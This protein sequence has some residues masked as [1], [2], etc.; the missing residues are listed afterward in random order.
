MKWIRPK[1]TVAIPNGKV[2][3]F[4]TETTGLFPRQGHRPYLFTFANLQCETGLIWFDVDPFTRRVKYE[5]NPDGLARLKQFFSDPTN[6]V[7]AHNAQFDKRMA[8]AALGFETKVQWFCT[9]SLIRVV[10]SDAPIKLKDF[11]AKYLGITN[12]D[13]EAV[14]KATAAARRDAKKKGWAMADAVEPDYWMAPVECR[15]YGVIDALR[16]ATV[17]N[18]LF[19]EVHRNKLETVLERE[20]RL[21]P[22]MRRI[23]DRGVHIDRVKTL[24]LIADL[25][26]KRRLFEL[27]ARIYGGSEMNFRSG[28]QLVKKL[29]GDFKEPVI[30]STK[31][32]NPAMDYDAMAAMEH[33]L[34]KNILEMRACTTTIKALDDYM[35]FM[36]KEERGW[37]I[38]PNLNQ[39]IP[40]TGRESCNNP[41]LQNVAAG[42]S[43]KGTEVK[44][45][46]R[47]VFTPPPEHEWRSYDW[48]N[49]EVYIPAFASGEKNLTQVLLDG[50]D[51]H[52]MTAMRLFKKTNVA[53]VT[54]LERSTAKRI[55]FGL[56]YGIGV[57]LL[58]KQLLISMGEA[59]D[60]IRHFSHTYPTMWDWMESLKRQGNIQGYITTAFGRRQQVDS[61]KTYRAVNYY[62][63]GTAADILKQSKLTL[64]ANA[65]TDNA[66][67]ILPIHD[68]VLFEIKSG[69][70]DMAKFDSRV[71]T[72]MQFHPELKI[73]VRIPVSIAAIK[74]NWHEKEKVRIAA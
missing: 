37:F 55:F 19:P 51:T 34:A 67:M 2:L 39:A 20:V 32:G 23:E 61:D 53:E 47:S 73:P 38:H 71:V 62:V 44:P 29:Y 64:A 69:Q 25:K 40:T 60:L 28:P 10:R 59:K 48:K 56:Q 57:K 41:N 52:T 35:R 42:E 54:P 50:G 6:T 30:Y 21:W 4:D 9:M 58:C 26:K 15:K 11:C 31:K 16:V 72:C 70:V 24:E 27:R 18:V 3:A 43:R 74:K 36:V 5:S 45:E 33:P 13:E 49:I 7:W 8:E 17:V 22:I 66:Y 65:E 68:E 63:Q 14:R 46:A 12:D 1:Q